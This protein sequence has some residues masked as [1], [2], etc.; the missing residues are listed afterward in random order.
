MSEPEPR[1]TTFNFEGAQVRGNIFEDIESSADQMVAAS[2]SNTRAT[3]GPR[4]AHHP[5]RR[6][7]GRINWVAITGIGTAIL[8]IVAIITLTQT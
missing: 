4:I 1:S 6:S 3:A 5:V 8:V 7:D 2:R